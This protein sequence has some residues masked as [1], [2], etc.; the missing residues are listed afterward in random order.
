MS[1]K[2]IWG[3]H[4]PMGNEENLIRGEYICIGWKELGNLSKIEPRTKEQFTK[5]YKKTYIDAHV[6]SISQCV[7]QIYRFVSEIKIGDYVVFPTKYNR[8]VNIGEIVGEYYFDATEEEYVHK[9][10]V[11]WFKHVQ[12]TDLTQGALYEMGSFLTLF[13]IKNYSDEILSIINNKK[14]RKDSEEDENIASTY[15]F[16]KDNTKDYLLK[17]L[18]TYYKGYDLED[19]VANL[20]EAMGYKTN[21]SKHGGDNGKDIV[22]YKDELPP[23]IIVQV[24]SQDG[25][26]PETTVQSL[27]GAM[28]EGDYGLFVTLSDYT[29]NAK[30]FLDTQPIIKAINGSELADLILKYYD[31]MPDSF[32]E[33]IKL[34]KVFI[35]IPDMNEQ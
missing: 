34:K 21:K 3:F 29:R 30:K 22:A 2:N 5:T 8:I 27:K 10:K 7:G 11:K 24:K 13:K 25:D 23:R 20:L 28:R 15:E 19:V 17:N 9:R 31:E 1:E 6:R 33:K 18:R 12:R 16:I 26:V 4:N 14:V 35:P 32:K